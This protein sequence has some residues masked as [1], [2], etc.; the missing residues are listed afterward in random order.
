MKQLRIDGTFGG[1][2]VIVDL[3]GEDHPTSVLSDSELRECL[4]RKGLS[5]VAIAQ[6]VKELRISRQ[7]T[8]TADR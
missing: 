3:S 7:S 1:G 6:A 4:R 5:D 8:V 2:Y